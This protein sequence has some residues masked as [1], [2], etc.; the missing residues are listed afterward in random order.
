M[1]PMASRNK[2]VAATDFIA[3]RMSIVSGITLSFAMLLTV[4]D[5]ILRRIAGHAL[6]G[7]FDIVGLTGAIVIGFSIPFSSSIKSHVYMEF[8]IDRL[9]EH[10]RKVMNTATR[11]VAIALFALISFNLF[12]VASM[13]FREWELSPTARVPVFPFVYAL[14]VCCFIE[15]FVFICDIVRVWERKHE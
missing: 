10:A 2:V 3:R 8:L 11:I 1:R 13:F 4:L 15:C 9:P 12:R 6:I 5:I 14:A 7:T